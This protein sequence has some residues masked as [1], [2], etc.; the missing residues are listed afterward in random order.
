MP[1]STEGSTDTDGDGISDDRDL[2]SDNDGMPDIIEGGGTDADGD[3]QADSPSDTDGDGL[4]D[5]YDP[6][7][8]GSSQPIPDTDGDEIPDYQ[9]LDSDGDG[10]LDVIEARDSFVPPLGSDSDGDGLD[11]A[12]DPDSSAPNFPPTDT[13]NDNIPDYRDTDTDGDGAPDYE[14]AFDFNDDGTPDVPPSHNDGNNNGVDDAFEPYSLPGSLNGN[15]RTIPEGNAE[16]EPLDISQKITTVTKARNMLKSR[17]KQFASRVTRCGGPRQSGPLAKSTKYSKSISTLIS[18]GYEGTIYDCPPNVCEQHA[19]TT[20]KS[21]MYSLGK[22]LGATAK[23]T[24]LR[25]MMSCRVKQGE[26]H[27]G[28]RRKG[29]DDYT[30]DLL[31]AIMALPSTVYRCE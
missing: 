27:K 15:W 19:L 10:V 29:S 23:T 13:D 31:A 4:P 26:R 25:A 8:A 20:T 5:Q 1:N 30:N 3:G 28:K 12:Y 7:D 22:K 17:A 21:Q 6:D 24:K 18:S 14:E 16:C 11:N 9:D 2:D